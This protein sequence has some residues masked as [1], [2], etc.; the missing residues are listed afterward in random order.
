MI[1]RL[2]RGDQ[3]LPNAF[4]RVRPE[5]LRR[6][7]LSGFGASILDVGCGEVAPWLRD[8]HAI[9]FT[10]LFGV[11]PFLKESGR[12]RGINFV[13]DELHH[14]ASKAPHSFELI[15]FNHSL[16]HI[17][18]QKRTMDAAAKLL[19][20]GGTCVIRIPLLPNAAWETFGVH[21]VELDAPRHLYIHSRKSIELLAGES[22]MAL[23]A[24]WYD[25]SSFELYGSELYAR[26]IPLTDPHSPWVNP[27]SSLFSKAEMLEFERCAIERNRA[28][29]AGRAVLEF[30]K[31]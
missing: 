12:R 17:P 11:D 8:L 14:F 6:A 24:I 2:L 30:R 19:R 21:W 16:E 26:G 5:L 3:E 27:S 9:G 1:A 18:D 13:K 15:A 25:T 4:F 23:T 28:G 31:L 22:G 29:T 10:R 20:T 7:A